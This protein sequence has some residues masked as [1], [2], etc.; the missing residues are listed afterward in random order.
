MSAGHSL[1]RAVVYGVLGAVSVSLGKGMQK[2]GLEF[3]EH[4]RK[5]LRERKY[6][7]TAGWLA[8]TAGIVSSAFFMFAACAYGAVS[9]VAALSGTGLIALVLF[10]TLVLK[11]PV[12]RS[13]IAGIFAV[14]LGTVLV[15]YF[16]GWPSLPSY[17]LARGGSDAIQSGNL[18]AFSVTVL[19]LSLGAALWCMRDGY[20]GFGVIFGSIS[21]FCGGISVFYQKA[22]M[23]RCAC[24]DV[25]D[26][27]PA[28]LRNP[29][30]YLF[31]FTGIGD[32]L[33]TQYALTRAKAVT[34]VPSYQ[35]W[36]MLVPVV[37][38]VV[39]FRERF[40]VVQVGGVLVLAAG[41]VLLSVFVGKNET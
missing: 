22:A 8:G 39:A 17:G 24:A 35:A 11:E 10:S 36:Y 9:L 28:A 32:F 18:A 6:L 13:E 12:G 26:N 21:G 30:F 3:I 20:R 15:G 7:K 29:Y 37:G 33:V 27:I 5:T 14:I 31:A 2:Y 19:A 34:V 40:N 38:G 41:T 16:D 4:P 23:L 1:V 25:F